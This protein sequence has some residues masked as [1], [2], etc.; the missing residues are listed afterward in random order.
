MAYKTPQTFGEAVTKFLTVNMR[1]KFAVKRAYDNWAFKQIWADKK[2]QASLRMLKIDY[3]EH[4][5][6]GSDLATS[7]FA[8]RLGGRVMNEKGK[9][10]ARQKDLPP[11]YTRNFRLLAV[12]LHNKSLLS[13]AMDNFA[14]LDHLQYL[15][16]SNNPRLDDFAC[17]Q[18]SR[19]FRNSRSFLEIDLSHNPFIS[20]C[21]LEILF[22]IPS[23]RRITAVGTRA[24]KH[25]QI[26][27]FTLAAK[28]ERDCDVF[29]HPN[30]RQFLDDELESIRL[31]GTKLESGNNPQPALP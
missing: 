26:D 30:N 31:E 25:D 1:T 24:S 13:E 19:Q 12:D 3:D 21:G 16:L 22:R 18:L 2:R 28:E 4:T 17:D 29:V 10:I 27:L 9:W 11:D 8:L 20:V 5:K 6:L 23:I 15:N 7:K 14:A